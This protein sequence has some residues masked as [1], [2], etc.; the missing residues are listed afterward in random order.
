LLCYNATDQYVNAVQRQLSHTRVSY[1]AASSEPYEY[2]RLDDKRF[3]C[4]TLFLLRDF[5]QHDVSQ[6]R[7]YRLTVKLTTRWTEFI[8]RN[9]RTALQAGCYTTRIRVKES[10]SPALRY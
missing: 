10:I 8:G 3:F 7:N 4:M 2:T 1:Y 6:Q 9:L 5:L